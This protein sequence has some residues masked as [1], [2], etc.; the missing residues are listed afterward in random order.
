MKSLGGDAQQGGFKVRLGIVL[1]DP[2][3]GRIHGPC[4]KCKQDVTI[5]SSADL[6]KAFTEPRV[7]LGLR[8]EGNNGDRS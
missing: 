8:L 4:P 5:A 7:R 6:S 1:L 2:S 3:D